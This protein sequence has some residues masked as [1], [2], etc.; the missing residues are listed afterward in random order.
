M[1]VGGI[2]L[3]AIGLL[4]EVLTVGVLAAIGWVC[5][6]VGVVLLVVALIMLLAGRSSV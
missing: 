4:L 5:V 1:L 3:L 6:V 2:I